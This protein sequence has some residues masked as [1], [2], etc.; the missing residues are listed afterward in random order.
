[1]TGYDIYRGGTLLT[2]VTGT[3]YS[4]TGFTA[5]T[6]Y[7][8]TVRAKDAAG[9][10]STQSSSASATTQ[11]ASQSGCT[12]S[13]LSWTCAAGSTVANI[14]AAINSASDGATISFAAGNYNWSTRITLSPTKGVTLKATPGTANVSVSG[15]AGFD[16]FPTVS[17]PY[18]ISGF[19]FTGTISTTYFFYIYP[20]S[21]LV[22]RDVQIDNNV[23][24]NTVG[25][26]GEMVIRFGD[27]SPDGGDVTGVVYKN[28]FIAPSPMI[29]VYQ[30]GPNSATAWGTSKRGTANNIFVEDNTFTFTSKSTVG[31][32][33]IDGWQKAGMVFRYNTVTNCQ[34]VFHEQGHEGGFTNAEL[35][36][37]SLS[38]TS[39]IWTDGDRLVFDQGGGERMYFNNVLFGSTGKSPY[40]LEITHYR[41]PTNAESGSGLPPCNGSQSFDGNWSPASTYHGY[42]CWGQPGR[43][44]AGAFGTLPYGS[45]SPIYSWLNRWQDGT[46]ANI[47]ISDPWNS[48]T[49]PTSVHVKANRDYYT[50]VSSGPNTSKTSPFNGTTGMGYGPI[51]NR[52]D[53][54]TASPN[55]AM[56]SGGGVG[57]WATDQGE[58]NSS[59]G[60]TPDGQLY[61]CSATN[62]WTL[63]YI[64]YQYPHP[65][66]SGTTPPP[67]DTT[68][69]VASN[70]AASNITQNSA[71]ITWTTNEPADSLVRYGLTTSYTAQS[72][73]DTSLLTSH[74]I[75]L[76]GLSANTTYNYRVDSRDGSGNLTTSANFTFT[77]QAAATDTQA[78]STPTNLSA[79]AISSSQINLSW[80]ASTDNVGVTGY[81]I[82]RGGT[83]L[84]TVTGTTYSNT[85]L[86]ANT[87][88]SYTVRAKDAAGNTSAQSSSASATTQAST[89]TG[90]TIPASRLGN[91]QNNVGIIGGIPTNYTNCT[92]SACNTLYG[93]TVTAASINAALASAPDNTVVRIP[94]GTY[95]INSPISL[96]GLNNV[97]LRGA[98]MNSTIINNSA[99][100]DNID[101]G[102]TGFLA[103]GRAITS[104]FNKGSTSIVV[105]SASGVT[106][107]SLVYITQRNE[108]FMRQCVLPSAQNLLSQAVLVT[109]V[110]GNTIN[111][112][113]GLMMDFN[114]AQSPTYSYANPS[115]S[116]VGLENF[117]LNSTG[118]PNYSVSLW[119]AN[120]VWFQGVKI[121][122]YADSGILA[123]MSN[124]IEVR[125]SVLGFSSARND[126]YGIQL[127]NEDNN[128]LRGTTSNSLIENNLFDG[129]PSAMMRTGIMNNGGTANVIAYN[130]ITR[131]S[132]GIDVW[133]YQGIFSN[134]KAHG[135]Y[136]LYEGNYS[137]AILNDGYHGSTSHDTYF[138]NSFHG[139][140][141]W[142]I[143]GAESGNRIMVNLARWS[144]YHN[145]IGNVLGSPRWNPTS[146]QM[147]GSP[148][149][150]AQP[151]IYRL[152][153]PNSHNNDL[154]DG[155]GC[156]APAGL[157]SNVQS[158][159]LRHKNYD[160][161]N[162]TV[163]LCSAESEGCQS[164]TGV[165]ANDTLPSSMYLAS[166]PAWFG[167]LSWPAIDPSGPTVNDIPAKVFYSTG[168]WPDE[169]GTPPPASFTIT[170]SAG[171]GG[172]I[173]PTGSVTV[174]Q[175][176][177]QTFTITPNT[178]YNISSVLVNG[179]SVGNVTTYTFSNVSSNQTIAVTFASAPKVAYTFR[180]SSMEGKTSLPS[181]QSL[182]VSVINP[183]SG[184]V[185]STT[186]LAPNGSGVYTVIFASGDP[187]YVNIRVKASGYLSRLVSNVNTT[188]SVATSQ[189]PALLAG[190]LNNDN[191]VNTI[192][193]SILSNTWNTS[194]PTADINQDG[195]VNS[196]D[197][198]LLSKNWNVAGE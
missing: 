57:Y 44:E 20:V 93:G 194:D 101:T 17:K 33:C 153:Y 23:F 81:D 197:F 127:R 110:S 61:R 116:K 15:S 165:T 189:L 196:I 92:T 47:I 76:T 180:L 137:N 4:N 171:T 72:T 45:L 187:V 87:T 154:T 136:N 132:V 128:P 41:S 86:T 145:V 133:Q 83:L 51:A 130:Y 105:G 175:G 135:M 114:A 3:S 120:E 64:P 67:S 9:N 10:T 58:W 139:D 142:L 2:S 37:N 172:S 119:W 164:A 43:K 5:N 103:S 39:G 143:N 85:G 26:N 66:V 65:L 181:G 151:T 121:T 161:F 69:P 159:I 89:G 106:A 68:P 73:L 59:N 34:L 149:Y 56:E 167:S 109:S 97:V 191:L 46:L 55:A 193:F 113:P 163:K 185:L 134:H 192:D 111:F 11:A 6:T 160:Y 166:K 174:T 141:P 38:T 8:Y 14:Q 79:S 40:A 30:L 173:S 53:T 188:A 27:H 32:G 75:T 155:V 36:G 170:A 178:G 42:P 146:Y 94:A 198:A 108:T 112:T 168:V 18:R 25:K 13:G 129:G 7:S 150:Y 16:A 102:Q 115:A 52:P 177:S 117:T 95:N 144:T 104:G 195:T 82:Y 126:G 48:A 90:F 19:N 22:L 156:G 122:G 63:D 70:I 186:S 24:N 98:G 131:N 182:D 158:T 162:K 74:S 91:W 62:T 1:V 21:G 50:S 118:N 80:T 157:D 147:S 140:A 71:T 183:A 12:G 96:S 184:A 29:S 99:G 107:G 35:Y 78:P 190:D 176:G 100:S 125:K 88:Y 123:N 31:M 84:T 169:S 124:R 49:Y 77:T 152:G 28:T 60:S 148:D 54:C 138:R 179:V